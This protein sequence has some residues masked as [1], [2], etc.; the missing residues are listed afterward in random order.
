VMDELRL[1]PRLTSRRMQTSWKRCLMGLA[2]PP[3]PAAA[4]RESRSTKGTGAALRAGLVKFI[5][6]TSIHG[7]V[8]VV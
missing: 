3:S 1:L 2:P 8:Y 6:P 4:P 5:H 7:T